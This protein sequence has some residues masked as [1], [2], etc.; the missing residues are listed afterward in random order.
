[1]LIGCEGLADGL[2]WAVGCDCVWVG[3]MMLGPDPGGVL[4]LEIST[5]MIATMPTAAAPIPANKKVRL[6]GPRG[7]GPRSGAPS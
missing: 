5:A 2:L 7:P 4:L 3:A 1:M 6:P